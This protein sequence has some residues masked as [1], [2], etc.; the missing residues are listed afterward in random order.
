MIYNEKEYMQLRWSLTGISLVAWILILVRPAS[1]S[2]WCCGGDCPT[3]LQMVMAV[4]APFPQIVEAVFAENP[5]GSLIGDWALMLLAMMTPTLIQPIHHIRANS[6]VRQRMRLTLLFVL[7]YFAAWIAA[8]AAFVTIM[9]GAKVL[10]PGSFLPALLVGVAALIWQSSPAK[11]RSLNRC[12]HHK[13]LSAFG[14]RADRDAAAMGL[15]HA[16]WCLYS[17]WSAMLFAMLLPAGHMMAMAVVSV[18]AIC[19]RLAPPRTPRW[20][21]RGFDAVWRYGSLQLRRFRRPGTAS[22]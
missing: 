11:Q 1:S 2:S 3:Q 17:C 6:F 10:M 7:G 9:L 16:G 14:T 18:L 20:Q 4:N 21:W 19:E 13:P 15:T 22:A 5:P 12:H 8:G